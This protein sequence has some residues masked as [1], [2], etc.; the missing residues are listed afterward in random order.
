MDLGS[1]NH[2]VTAIGERVVLRYP[3]ASD[4][5][6]F[7]SLR[8]SSRDHLERWEPIPPSGLDLYSYEAF[9]QE[10]ESCNTASTQRWLICMKDSGAIAGRITL[11]NIERGPFQNGRFGYWIGA[12]FA[13]RGLMSEALSLAVMHA[14]TS[15]SSG[16]LGLHRVCANIV[17][18]NAASRRVLEKVGFV[19]EGYSEKYLQIQGEWE[20]HERWAMTVTR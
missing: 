7:V 18:T 17:P 6:E 8:R 13:G 14:F 10:L 9:G 12:E 2:V 5:E 19:K 4:C 11:G 3:V 16:G 15:V 20:D 1:M